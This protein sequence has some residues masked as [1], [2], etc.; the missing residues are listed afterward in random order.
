M[1]QSCCGSAEHDGPRLGQPEQ[2]VR[3]LGSV[4]HG[5]GNLARVSPDGPYDHLTGV[6]A[7]A[8]GPLLRCPRPQRRA[9]DTQA[10]LEA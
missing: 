10:F 8:H 6:H 2:L 4:A 9:C 1:N 5:Q 3:H 7:Q